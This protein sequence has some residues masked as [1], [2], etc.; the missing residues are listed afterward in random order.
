VSSRDYTLPQ[1]D[2][3]ALSTLNVD[4]TR[5]WMSPRTSKGRYWRARAIVAW[6]LIVIFAALPWIRMNGKP[7]LLLDIMT[8]QF[9]FFGTTFRPTETLLLSLLLLS[10]FVAVFLATAVLGRVW[11][12]WACPQTVYMEFLY[13]PAEKLL[14]GKAYGRN[15]QRAATWRVILLYALF[16]LFSAHLANTFL[17][18]F[19]GTDRLVAWTLGSP[20]NHPTA[21]AVFAVTLGLMLF[22]FA[23]FRE[24]LCTL[25]CP[26][27]RFQS[28]LLD[29][30]S[31][32]IGY[33]QIRG[34][35]RAKGAAARV[36][37]QEG[38]PVGDCIDCTMCVQVCPT[39]IDIRQGL[40]LECVNCAQCVD[41]CDEV[42][43]KVGLPRG[44]VRYGTQNTLERVSGRRF[45]YR[46]VIYST[47]LVALVLTLV[48]LLVNRSSALVGQARIIGSN[49]TL[50]P[51][52]R[53]VTP[54]QLMV[55][56]RADVER[57]YTI[58]GVGDLEIQGGPVTVSVP[59]AD[60]RTITCNVLSPAATFVRGVRTATIRVTDGVDYDRTTNVA[61][62]G[63]FT[64][65]AQGEHP[66]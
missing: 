62:T 20:W 18:Y 60:A 53:V 49:F 29:R 21:F 11:C 6:L 22:D 15:G 43:D 35:P 51:D 30:N 34:E 5:R 2:E 44:L 59:P 4:G 56:N 57:T 54:L 31:I 7:V 27:G 25:V 58:Q 39:G 52:L 8:R 46:L 23:F 17:A 40:Q 32:I 9:T 37:R 1:L 19:V 41:A 33:D 66:R 55:E 63:P 42:M 24:Q 61:L 10:I 26:Y 38:T 3:R 16:L 12:G 36:L 13:R 47:A 45:R 65:A 14:L 28:V 48:M 50:A 64:A